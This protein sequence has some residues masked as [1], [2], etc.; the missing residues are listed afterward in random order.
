MTLAECVIALV[1]LPL[2]VMAVSFAVTSGQMQS[3]ET[4]RSARAAELAEALMEEI[5]SKAYSDPQGGT[6]F[7]KETGETTRAQMDDMDDFLNF[8]ETAGNL[9]DATNTAYPTAFQKFSRTATCASGSVTLTGLGTSTLGI[10]ITVV[11]SEGGAT[12]VTLTRFVAK[13]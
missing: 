10:T 2:A 1:I 6:T 11:V 12:L 3:V 4:I 9:K 8:S 5:L 13:P 7:G